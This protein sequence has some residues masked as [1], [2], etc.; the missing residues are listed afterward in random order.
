[1]LSSYL[2]PVVGMGA[3]AGGLEAFKRL[4]KA[5]PE[6]SGMAYILVQ[7]LDPSHDSILSEILQR[8]TK[9]PI[10]EII[11]NVHVETDHIYIIPSNKLLT[12]SD[13]VLQ[14]SERLPKGEKNMPIDLFFS[15]LAAVHQNHAI[16][17]VLSGTGADGT[18]GLKT[19]KEHSGITFAQDPA[20]AA[21]DGMPQSAIDAG[22]VDFIVTPENLP[23][24]LLALSKSLNIHPLNPEDKISQSEEDKFR[25]ILAILQRRKEVD[26]THYKQ[27]TIRR[28]INRR[29]ALSMKGSITAYITYLNANE[30]EQDALFQDL[31]IPVTEFFRDKK[32]FDE[33]C[34]KVFPALLKNRPDDEPFRL[35]VAG[36]STGEE[37]YSL[38]MCIKEYLGDNNSRLNIQVFATDVSERAIIKARTGIYTKTEVTGLSAGR[39]QK[40]FERT[41]GNYRLHKSIRDI[42]IFAHHNFLK[43]APFARIDLI[44]CRNALIYLEPILQ[45]NVLT[46]FHYAL[47]EKGYLLL[48]KSETASQAVE[49]FNTYDKVNKIYTRKSVKS[50]FSQVISQRKTESGKMNITGSEKAE[51]IK[52][53]FQ[54]NADEVLLSRFAP[55]GVVVNNDL[56]IVQFRGATGIWLEPSPGKPNLNVLKMTRQDLAFELR[57]ALYK[58]QKQRKDIIK[59]DIP[60]QI[61]GKEHL[62]RLEVIPLLHTLMPHFLVLFTDTSATNSTPGEL[63]NGQR[64]ANHMQLKERQRNQKLQQQLVQAREDMRSITEDQEASNEELQSANEELLSG[65]EELQSL[66]EE[67]ETSK[68]EIQTSNE[69]LITVNQELNDRNE[70]LNLSRLYAESIVTTIR[71]PLII[72]NKNLRVIS[73][74]RSYLNKFH[75]TGEEIE[76]KL[77]FDLGDKQWNIPRL[78]KMVE[79]I[80]PGKTSIVDFEVMRNFQ[81]AGERTLLI[82]AT[83]IF[84]DNTQE[85]SI[86]I[87][88]EDITEKRKT[89]KELQSFAE[90]L[91]KQVLERT[92]SLN[93]AVTELKH[94]NKNLE[95]FAYIASHDLQEPLRKIRTFSGMLQTKF[96]ND[97]PK[98]A[99][100]LMTKIEN[101]SERM[102]TLIK[103]VLN[104][105]KIIHGDAALEKTNLNIVISNV[106]DDFELL[107][108][109]KRAV[110]HQESLP[111][112]DAIPLQMSQL[113]T[114]LLSNSLKFSKSEVSP[115]ISISSTNLTHAQVKAHKNLSQKLTY[116]SIIFKD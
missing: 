37:A 115:V 58:A 56:D 47:K 98:G 71:E 11:D 53:D 92:A 111:S 57:N 99:S 79:K 2:F 101:S 67:L 19:I 83:Q 12:A 14:L 27:T 54:K 81:D 43:D 39:L 102:S 35:W 51:M 31:L 61:S 70:Q 104:F 84:R 106:I 50:K 29:V 4:I 10:Q 34:T 40:Y 94:S 26:F 28:R 75:T 77:L 18:L 85:Q 74:N 90:E 80:L 46:T 6:N 38:A 88:I 91:E 100:D 76:G 62:V 78:R 66:N 105:S 65:S 17:V 15:S 9:I 20:S 96:R 82:N 86:L 48:G 23:G 97:L 30:S 60:I 110:I 69:E 36:C 7:H 13:G 5:I 24:Q 95:Q 87:A 3:S 93:E 16:G 41:D 114:N 72:L 63:H 22:V 42:C 107:I 55:S 109:E 89:D 73:A 32:T 44:S 59:E 49:L 68:E 45:K 8:L 21:S 25:Q 108:A 52:D 103:G 116:C 112:I 113:F 64:G 33:V 1:L